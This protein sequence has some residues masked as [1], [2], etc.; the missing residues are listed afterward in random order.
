MF[1]LSDLLSTYYTYDQQRTIEITE[2]LNRLRQQIVSQL[3]TIRQAE[4][5]FIQAQQHCLDQM[6][7]YL[8]ADARTLLKTPAFEAF[9]ELLLSRLE[10]AVSPAD[11]LH[12]APTPDAWQ[13]NCVPIEIHL[14]EVER[15]QFDNPDGTEGSVA[16]MRMQVEINDWQQPVHVSTHSLRRRSEVAAAIKEIMSQLP[17]VDDCCDGRTT[18]LKLSVTQEL[19]CLVLYVAQL[20]NVDSMG[21]HFEE[22]K[23]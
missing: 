4:S 17:R 23:L 2:R 3:L 19:A 9:V 10:G 15:M 16:V 7:L 20:F 5:K 21:A 1:T 8:T 11:A 18:Q 14:H 22:F 6:R 12:I 13:L